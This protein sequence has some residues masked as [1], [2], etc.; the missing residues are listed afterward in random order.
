MKLIS[1]IAHVYRA[2]A[3]WI[4]TVWCRL[5]LQILLIAVAMESYAADGQANQGFVGAKSNMTNQA[6]SFS[7]IVQTIVAALGVGFAAMGIWKLYQAGKSDQSREEAGTGWRLIG[8]GVLALSMW[9]LI[10]FFGGVIWGDG[11]AAT[12]QQRTLIQ[13]Q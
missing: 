12:Q 7:T 11:Q 5:G 10:Y 2:A 1:T 8:I 9:G 4:N 13:Q 3:R 6:S